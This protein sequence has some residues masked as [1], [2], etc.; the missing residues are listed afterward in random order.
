MPKRN[1]IIIVGVQRCGTTLLAK[2]LSNHRNTAIAQIMDREPKYFLK[3]NPD[4]DSYLEIFQPPFSEHY[5]EKSVSY[6]NSKEARSNMQSILIQPK[7][8]I[9]LRDPGRRAISHYNFSKSNRIENLKI[10]EVLNLESENRPWK[11]LGVSTNPYAYISTGLYVQQIAKWRNCFSNVTLIELEKLVS[12]IEVYYKLMKFLEVQP[13]P[14]KYYQHVCKKVNSTNN[15]L[16]S[17]K[18]Y[19][20]ISDEYFSYYKDFLNHISDIK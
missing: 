9:M 11:H 2:L 5:I 3:V 1:H 18:I 15:I 19:H 4:L 10:E 8:I 20:K 7:I 13:E 16:V 12:D 17:D 6:F 14:D